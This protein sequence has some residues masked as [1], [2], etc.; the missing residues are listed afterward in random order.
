MAIRCENYCAWWF[1]G[2]SHNMIYLATFKLA[3]EI[4]TNLLTK[5]H[6]PAKIVKRRTRWRGVQRHNDALEK[7]SSVSMWHLC[8]VC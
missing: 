8:R 2:K 1:S 3:S 4:Q 5:T 7:H 6:E